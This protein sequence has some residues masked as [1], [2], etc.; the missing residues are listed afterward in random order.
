MQCY[1][2]RILMAKIE[3]INHN[4]G[5]CHDDECERC[6]LL[7]DEG[8][9][10][11]CDFCGRPERSDSSRLKMVTTEEIACCSCLYEHELEEKG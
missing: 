1:Q 4:W 5:L 7:C 6:Q 3:D 11:A 8:F 2:G 10:M 9:V